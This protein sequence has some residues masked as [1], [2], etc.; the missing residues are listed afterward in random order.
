MK[1]TSNP[2]VFLM[3][4]PLFWFAVTM[5]LSFLSGWFGLMERYPDRPETALAVLARQS[6]SLGIVSMQRILKLG[7]CPSGLRIGMMRIFGPFSR[8]F[9]VPWDEIT[10]SRR[11]RFIFKVAKLSFGRPPVGT[12]TLP[13]QVADRIARAAGKPWPES[14][15]FPEEPKAQALSR[16]LKQWAAMTILAAAFFIIAPRLKSP[17]AANGP[18]IAVAVLFPAIVF[19]I[20]AIVQYVRRNRP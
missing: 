20:G 17:H 2:L 9:F 19:G 4:F 18:P 14:G 5:L 8:D 13:A 3:V 16:L 7:I 15:P 10:V 6:G 11:D 12:L 1:E